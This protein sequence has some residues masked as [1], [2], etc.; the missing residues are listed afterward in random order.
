MSEHVVDR[1]ESYTRGTLSPT[2]RAAIESHLET[3]D[4]CRSAFESIRVA[5]DALSSRT[6]SRAIDSRFADRVVA[7]ARSRRP[8][9]LGYRVAAVV[10]FAVA[11]G[12][13]GFV[14]G[15]TSSAPR[16]DTLGTDTTLHQ[17]IM[18]L[19]EPVWPPTAPLD[20]SGYREWVQTLAD[21]FVGAEKLTEELGYRIERTG[22]AHLAAPPPQSPNYSGWY[23]VK[24]RSYAEAIALARRGPHLAYG[25]ILVRQVE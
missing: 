5:I 4:D 24:A 23:V 6:S 1:A 9:P 25:S 22:D 2:D 20:R 18:L 7:A 17:F 14:A 15:R 16:L 12:A 19:E 13:T 10:A 21:R 3:C 11:C 8:T